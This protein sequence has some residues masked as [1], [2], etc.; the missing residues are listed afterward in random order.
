[1]QRD[2]SRQVYFVFGFLYGEAEMMILLATRLNEEH[3]GIH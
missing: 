1:M 3:L 2:R